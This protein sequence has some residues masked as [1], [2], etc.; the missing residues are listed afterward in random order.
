M[1]DL[2][3]PGDILVSSTALAAIGESVPFE[4]RG[5]HAFKGVEGIWSVYSIIDV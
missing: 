3:G 4:P 1:K 2:A 5:E